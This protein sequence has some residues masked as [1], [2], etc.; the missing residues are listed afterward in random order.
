VKCDTCRVISFAVIDLDLQQVTVKA[1]KVFKTGKNV[2][3][4]YL[5][6]I[7]VHPYT[8]VHFSNVDVWRIK[9]LMCLHSVKACVGAGCYNKKH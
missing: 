6:S 4:K 1:S 3:G 9:A 5:F 8:H 7:G 2:F